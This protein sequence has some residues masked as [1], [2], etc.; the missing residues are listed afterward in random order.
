ME[1]LIINRA[2]FSRFAFLWVLK[3]IIASI[4]II[5]IAPGA[6]CVNVYGVLLAITSRIRPPPKAVRNVL[7]R[8]PKRSSLLRTP[9]KKPLITKAIIPMYSAISNKFSTPH[10]ESL[11][12][13]LRRFYS[14]LACLVQHLVVCLN[15]L[16]SRIRF[17][18]FRRLVALWVV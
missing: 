11:L 3:I 15:S 13:L 1:S 4:S 10:L 16:I 6:V 8:I 14:C 18:Q 2:L 7:I 5:T 12:Q 9:T 17:Y